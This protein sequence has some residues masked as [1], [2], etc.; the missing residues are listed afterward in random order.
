MTDADQSFSTTT[1]HSDSS[2]EIGSFGFYPP[3]VYRRKKPTSKIDI[4]PLGCCI[5]YLLTNGRRPHE[6]ASD[7][8]N[9]YLLNANVQ[10]GNFSLHPLMVSAMKMTSSP[11]ERL[12]VA[13]AVDF[14][15]VTIAPT[16]AD[17]P[18]ARWLLNWHPFLWPDQKRF[19]FLC[20]VANE[21]EVVKGKGSAMGK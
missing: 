7:P 21:E 11:R 14:I 13:E 5:F 8:S 6:D 19:A 2:H 10:T 4:F 3:E 1:D 12:P 20:T 15:E 16:P 18:F 17:R 9:K